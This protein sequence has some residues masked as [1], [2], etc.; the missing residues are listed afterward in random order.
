M[1]IYEF[2]AYNIQVENGEVKC[3]VKN[4]EWKETIDPNNISFYHAR[5]SKHG[6]VLNVQKL[7]PS[8]ITRKIS[9]HHSASRE[10]SGARRGHM[11]YSIA[12]P[13][14]PDIYLEMLAFS[15][16]IEITEEE[17]SKQEAYAQKHPFPW[18]R[19]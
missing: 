4:C 2:G 14:S 11:R 6:L 16:C 3:L 7:A 9:T 1:I 13:G 19:R 17:W 8:D 5:E 15:I 18:R 10:T 12:V